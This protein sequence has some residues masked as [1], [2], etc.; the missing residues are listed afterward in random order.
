MATQTD[1]IEDLN[2]H[3]NARES[4]NVIHI[5]GEAGMKL[6]GFIE[7]APLEWKLDTGAI[8]TFITEDAYYSILPEQRTTS[9]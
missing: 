4:R 2:D 1:I 6:K 3:S 5:P 9:T 7:G 8:N